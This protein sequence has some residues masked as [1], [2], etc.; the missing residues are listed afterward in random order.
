[1]KL[2]SITGMLAAFLTAQS[3]AIAQ[4]FFPGHH[5]L[6]TPYNPRSIAAG[7]SFVAVR[8]NRHAS[9]HNPAGLSGIEGFSLSF[10]RRN[11]NHSSFAPG[12]KYIAFTGTLSTP[13]ADFGIVYNRFHQG[14]VSLTSSQGPEVVGTAELSDYVLGICAATEII[15][16]VDIGLQVKTFRPVVNVTSGA[17]QLSNANN[18]ILF[19]FGLIGTIDGQMTNTSVGYAV[20]A[21]VAIQNFGT[22]LTDEVTD[23]TL[24]VERQQIL[25]V[26]RTLRAGL[27]FTISTPRLDGLGLSPVSIM[28]TGEYRLILNS[29]ADP[30]EKFWGFGAELVV[31]EIFSGRIGG[32]IPTFTSIYGAEGSPALRF[33]AGVRVPFGMMGL[34]TP[35]SLCVDYAA[36]PVYTRVPIPTENTTLHAFSIEFVYEG[37]LFHPTN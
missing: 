8:S 3:V 28:V 29:F 36:I 18:P 5:S 30:R 27:A 32:F 19:D 26:P 7:E 9:M 25:T 37:D 34:R 21:G 6:D 11:L 20:S 17:F 2:K 1:M 10:S 23:P 31:L 4:S 24:N 35:L 14:E 16:G 15:E 13:V 12:F 22:N 33:G